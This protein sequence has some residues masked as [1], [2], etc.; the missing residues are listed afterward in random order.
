[1]QGQLCSATLGNF[2]ANIHGSQKMT[3]K[4]LGDQLSFPFWTNH[5]VWCF[6]MKIQNLN[7]DVI[8]FLDLSYIFGWEG[9]SSFS[10][11]VTFNFSPGRP[12]SCTSELTA[13]WW[14][15]QSTCQGLW[16]Q[17][18]SYTMQLLTLSAK[19]WRSPA[20]D[21]V[22]SHWLGSGMD[23]SQHGRNHVPGEPQVAQAVIHTM[24]MEVVLG[25]W[26][27]G[28]QASRAVGVNGVCWA[29]SRPR[30][31]T[32]RPFYLVCVCGFFNW[33][34]VFFLTVS[35]LCKMQ[36]SDLIYRIK[37]RKH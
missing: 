9:R 1:M 2:E 20:D 37:G 36:M 25:P 16:P 32:I 28:E 31:F 14:V 21:F 34:D 7:E 24:C 35:W 12:L 23:N 5:H 19:W 18:P 33:C 26:G 8:R 3:P 6:L 30:N 13:C 29:G 11:E 22:T 15:S 4:Y 17:F 27:G 10:F